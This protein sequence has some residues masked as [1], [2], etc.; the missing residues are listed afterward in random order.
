MKR[1][2]KRY[3]AMLLGLM[4]LCTTMAGCNLVKRAQAVEP[5]NKEDI[6]K[7]LENT[8][9]VDQLDEDYTAG[10]NAFALRVISELQEGENLFISPYSISL[11]LSM[12]YNG[13][14][15]KTREEMAGMLGFDQLKD[16]TNDYSEA[17]NHH[18]NANSS[19]LM[20][21]LEKADPKVKLNLANSI[22]LAEDGEFNESAEQALLAPARFYYDGDIFR[23]DFKEDQT[24]DSI[25]QWVSD[26]TNQMIDPFLES[27]SDKAML[28]LF[29]V[30]AI[31][32]NGEWSEP[33]EPKDTRKAVFYGIEAQRKVDMMYMNK[34]GFR[35]L[36]ENGIKG[37]ELPYGDGRIVMNVLI[38]EEHKSETIDELFDAFSEQELTDY[39][40]KLDTTEKIEI[41]T[42]QLP[43]FELEYGFKVINDVLKEL[44][45]EEAFQGGN[46]DFELIGKDLFV[47]AVSHKAKIRVE[48]WGTEAAAATGVEVNCTSAMPVETIDFIVNRPFIFLIRDTQTDTILFVG[49][50]NQLE[51]SN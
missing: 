21:A 46:A 17:S 28:R 37:I 14:D 30:N 18:M 29:L 3:I 9:T 23:V 38:P 45:M 10:L 40:D 51:Y 25:N 22:W 8:V 6:V 47:S 32:F 13:A 5:V 34:S 4:I 12:L 24:L 33:F 31:Y 43:K 50:I 42:L 41:G 36:N 19:F 26:Q 2:I 49:Q 15:E 11:A 20:E 44:G 35:Y 39:L 7:N 48:E 1:Q 27:F 16:Y